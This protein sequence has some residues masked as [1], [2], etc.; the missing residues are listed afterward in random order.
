LARG[1]NRSM[2]RWRS[3]ALSDSESRWPTATLDVNGP[4]ALG[5]IG[6][7]LLGPVS[8]V[9]EIMLD[10]TAARQDRHEAPYRLGIAELGGTTQ[11]LLGLD[12]GDKVR[13]VK[14]AVEGIEVVE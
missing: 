7:R 12:A 4:H 1:S 8:S 14:V 5:W 10:R 9:G 13:L 3:S 11:S 2:P 6:Q